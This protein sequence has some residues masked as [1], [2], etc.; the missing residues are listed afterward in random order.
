M[1][2]PLYHGLN[3]PAT[4]KPHRER[5]RGVTRLIG[6]TTVQREPFLVMQAHE[7]IP[8]PRD[9]IQERG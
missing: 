9:L 7:A 6:V 5:C 4:Q 8:G 1:Y 2:A 3:T